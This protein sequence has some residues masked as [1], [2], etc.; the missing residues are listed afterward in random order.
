MSEQVARLR[1]LRLRLAEAGLEGL[2][3]SSASNIFYLSGFRGS[4]GA[5]LITK[6]C[7]LLFSD[8]RYRLQ[9]RQQSPDFVFIE[10]EKK[11]LFS[12]G[13]VA[14][15]QGLTR[16]G[17]DQANLTCELF[18]QLA[19]GAEGLELTPAGGLVEELRA[20][21][22]KGEIELVRKAASLADNALSHM[23]NLLKPGISERDIALEGEFFMRRAG[24]EAIA[25]DIIVASGP[26]SAWPHAETTER[27]LQQGDLVVIDMG[28]R[29]NGYCSDMT[30]TFIIQHA[31]P[32]AKEIYKIVYKAQR[33][34]AE[35][36]KAG[37][38]GGEVDRI[39]RN[40]I[41]AAGY[42]AEFGHSLGHG[43][44]IEVHEAPRLRKGEESQLLPGHLVTVEPGIYLEDMGGVRLE[45]LLVV[46]ENGAETLTHTPM[47]EELP[48]I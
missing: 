39:A 3:V 22:S 1:R 10:I 18:E 16:I 32:Q 24:A 28:A 21:K 26:N 36:V 31:S 37:A 40:L 35:A 46:E 14:K 43:V 38:I 11:L 20:V 9:A 25:F 2:V 5:L 15:E 13:E 47:P 42:G 7:A 23:I 41:E 45:D 29:V 6:D 34:A 33:A 19:K 27:P 4:S 44:G 48:V 17:Y 8:F 30:R 12:I